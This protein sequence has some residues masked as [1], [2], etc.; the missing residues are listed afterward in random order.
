[1]LIRGWSPV[2]RMSTADGQTVI[3]RRGDI[4]RAGTDAVVNAANSRLAPGGGVSGAIHRA[5]GPSIAEECRAYV[6]A[7][8]PVQTGDAVITTGGTLPAGRVIHAVGPVWHG[9]H[10]GEVEA[11]GAAYRSSI[12]VAQ[13]AGLVSLAFPSISTGIFGYPVERAAPVA[14]EAIADALR[15]APGIREVEIVLFDEPTYDAWLEAVRD[16][17]EDAGW[18]AE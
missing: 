7:H 11:L 8:G 10:R 6:A 5:G 15:C 17:E 2:T 16:I 18:M 9:G 12:E 4:T 1:M 14:L 13:T 3:I